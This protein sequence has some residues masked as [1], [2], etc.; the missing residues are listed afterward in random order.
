MSEIRETLTRQLLDLFKK[1]ATEDWPWFEPVLSYVNPK[2][3]HALIVSGRDS[4]DDEALELGLQTLRWIS[5]KQTAPEGWFR[6][7]GS[8]WTYQRDGERP[9]FDQQ[10][11][12]AHAMVS[13]SVA[14]YEATRNPLWITEAHKAFDWF[15]GR[16]DLGQSLYN[17]T[18]NG[19]YDGLHFD[20][21][22][23]NQGAESLLAYLLSLVE[24]RHL[25]ATLVS[26]EP[27]EEEEHNDEEKIEAEQ[28]C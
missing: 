28:A 17:P 4:G 5:W 21:V 2:L 14:A 26:F 8:D 18:S 20:R 19:C 23:H 22:N 27:H 10:P 3:P 12:E 6:P 15:L 16:N 1:Q 9:D 11:I 7:I 13:A 24:L 25:D